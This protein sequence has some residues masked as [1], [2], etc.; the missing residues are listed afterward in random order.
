MQLDTNFLS[1]LII[2]VIAGLNLYTAI[3]SRNTNKNMELVEKSTNSMKDALVAAT[4]KASLAEGT[5]IGLKQGREE[6]RKP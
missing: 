3:I 6:E 4:A 1:L 2:L 5:A